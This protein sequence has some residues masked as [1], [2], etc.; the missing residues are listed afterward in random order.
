MEISPHQLHRQPKANAKPLKKSPMPWLQCSGDDLAS[1][2]LLYP[3]LDQFAQLLCLQ[4][5]LPYPWIYLSV[6]FTEIL[7]FHY[8]LG[9]QPEFSL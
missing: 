3:I 4:S 2:C 7:Q 6:T 5:P 1:L 8:P 9:L